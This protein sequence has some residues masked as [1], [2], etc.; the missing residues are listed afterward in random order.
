MFSTNFVLT[1][2]SFALFSSC[3]THLRSLR[4][5]YGLYHSL[6]PR[7]HQGLTQY[8]GPPPHGPCCQLLTAQTMPIIA[9]CSPTLNPLKLLAE[10]ARLLSAETVTARMLQKWHDFHP[11][12]K[13]SSQVPGLYHSP[14]SRSILESTNAP[15]AAIDELRPIGNHW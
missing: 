2:Q 10:E 3:A 14:S 12:V 7:T 9:H 5:E 4:P 11:T 8:R 13:A 15:I 6:D 1:L